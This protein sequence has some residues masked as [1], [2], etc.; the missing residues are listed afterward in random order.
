M[1]HQSFLP[2]VSIPG[3]RRQELLASQ[4]LDP[5]TSLYQRVSL[6]SRGRKRPLLS[7]R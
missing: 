1:G 3:D 5:E 7:L 6:D 2:R 4:G